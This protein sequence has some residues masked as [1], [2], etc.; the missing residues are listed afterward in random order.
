LT[1]IIFNEVDDMILKYREEDGKKIE[2][3]YYL[4]ILPMLLVNGSVGIGTGWSTDVPCFNPEDVA[5][6]RNCSPDLAFHCIS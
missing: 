6:V 4:P 5:R 1:R 3:E 2:P